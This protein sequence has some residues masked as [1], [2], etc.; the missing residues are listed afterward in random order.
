VE[1]DLCGEPDVP[2]QTKEALYRIAQEAL[3]NTVK[4][5]QAQRVLLRLAGEHGVVALEVRDDGAE[6]DTTGAFPGHLGLQSM[7]ERVE[8]LHGTLDVTSA[9]AQERASPRAFPC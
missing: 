4:H 1:A 7:R 5:A 3:H 6:F 8:R 2:L 9:P